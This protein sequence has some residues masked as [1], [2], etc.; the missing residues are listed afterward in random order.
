MRN[1]GF[2]V[3]KER[4]TVNNRFYQCKLEDMAGLLEKM[5]KY[6]RPRESHDAAIKLMREVAQYLDEINE[7]NQHLEEPKKRV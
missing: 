2:R 3:I 1:Q 4:S 6:S 5:D 7:R